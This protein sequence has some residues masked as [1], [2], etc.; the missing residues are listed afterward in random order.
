VTSERIQAG[1]GPGLILLA[2]LV[3]SLRPAVAVVVVGA[4]LLLR[5]RSSPAAIAWAAVLPVA[6]LLT[7]PWVL[8]GDAPMGEAGCTDPLSVI[9][10][11]RVVAAAVVLGMAALVATA[12]A[13]SARELG[14]R[15]PSR[16]E[17]AVGAGG[18]TAIAVGGLYLGPWIAGPF[19]G[20]LSYP[21]PPGALVPALAFGIANGVLEEVG[22]RG[23]L[24]GLLSRIA[25]ISVAIGFQGLL[26]GIVH[27]GPDVVALLPVH[28]ALLGMVGVAAGVIRWRTGSLAIPIA[29]H[30]GADVALYVGLACRAAG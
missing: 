21:V 27:A 14:F 26:F 18:Y 20:D 30:V 10:L 24:Q 6:V 16:L 13:A 12:H 19:F 15:R 23:I 29:L 7:A 9:A 3:P 22:Y 28:V 11:R 8:G 1:A 17:L 5:W 2:A 25:P 4:W